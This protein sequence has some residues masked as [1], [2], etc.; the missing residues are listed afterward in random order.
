MIGRGIRIKDKVKQILEDYPQCRGDDLQL[1][2]RYYTQY[3]GIRMKFSMFRELLLAPA[4][5]T[6]SRRR[7]ELQHEYPELQPTKRTRHKRERNAEAHRNYFGNGLT[8]NDF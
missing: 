6:L 7:R 1:V 2:W 3:T 5:E 4:P 8:L